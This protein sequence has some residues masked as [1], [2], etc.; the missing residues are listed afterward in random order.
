MI[1][2]SLVKS[3]K[4]KHGKYNFNQLIEFME[5]SNIIFKDRE[6]ISAAGIATYDC[7]YIDST[8]FD[9]RFPDFMLYFII[10]HEM[11]HYK[12]LRKYGK[13]HFIKELSNDNYDELFEH[14]IN[15]EILADRYASRVFY[16]LNKEVF[17]KYYTQCLDNPNKKAAYR[18]RIEFFFGKV[19]NNEEKYDDLFKEFIIEK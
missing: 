13:Q 19:Q 5:A 16:K 7:I 14:V 2:E 6:L 9:F 17:P 4:D 15:E 11:A 18:Y 12:R 8:S 3:L 10:L 1:D